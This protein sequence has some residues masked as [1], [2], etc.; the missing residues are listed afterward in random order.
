MLSLE[1]TVL[2]AD[3]NPD[4]RFLMSEAW[5]E[6]GCAH[7]LATVGD[8]EQVLSYLNGDG[9]YADRRLHPLPGL[10]IL[11]IKMPRKSGLETLE[12]IRGSK[13]WR[14]VPVLMLTASTAPS[15]LEAGYR[16]CANAFLV[17]PGTVRELIEMVGAIR[18]FWL[19]FAEY[20]ECVA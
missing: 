1:R 13:A 14:N 3:D 12:W 7:A 16:L 18:G 15:D 9:A 19:R 5:R 11:D 10:I 6:A 17:K 20:P 8:G 4:D 2:F